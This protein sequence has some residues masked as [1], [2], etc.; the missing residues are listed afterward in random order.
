VCTRE[1]YDWLLGKYIVPQLGD[2][3]LGKITPSLVRSWHA[4]ISRVGSPTPVRQSYSL[5]RAML[6]MAVADEIILRNPCAIKGAR[7][8]G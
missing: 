5:L 4:E 8:S 2:V 6:A 1:L 3:P 7:V